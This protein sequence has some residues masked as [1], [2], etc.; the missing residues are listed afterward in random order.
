MSEINSGAQRVGRNVRVA[1]V[2]HGT[3]QQDIAQVLGLVQSGVTRRLLG[4][5]CFRADEL[6]AIAE[7]LGV[8]PGRFFRPIPQPR[9]RPRIED[10]PP[11]S[12]DVDAKA[13]LTQAG[14]A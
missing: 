1:L 10:L 5:V 7:H 12:D 2:E 9:R 8:D 4:E 14:A 11:T 13:N 3:T 6:L